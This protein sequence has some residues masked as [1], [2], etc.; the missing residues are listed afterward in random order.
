MIIIQGSLGGSAANHLDP[1]SFRD[2]AVLMQIGRGSPGDGAPLGCDHCSA[3]EGGMAENI[4]KGSKKKK[5]ILKYLFRLVGDL[6]G[7]VPR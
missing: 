7:A 6:V 5:K 4:Y 2:R 3:A 1:R